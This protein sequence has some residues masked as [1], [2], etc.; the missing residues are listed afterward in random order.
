MVGLLRARSVDTFL[1]MVFRLAAFRLVDK[2]LV[3][4]PSGFPGPESRTI[5]GDRR[6]NP[7]MM[8]S[9]V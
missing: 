7:F 1:S 3:A 4:I 8:G 6:L 5:E 2:G 9:R